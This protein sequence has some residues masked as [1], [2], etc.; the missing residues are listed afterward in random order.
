MS[1]LRVLGVSLLLVA[2]MSAGAWASGELN[3]YSI[4]PEKYA[5]Q[6]FEA[7]TAETGIK[8]NVKYAGTDAAAALLL[9]EGG[10]SPADV[11][12]SQDG[13]ALGAVRE[14]GLLATLPGSITAPGRAPSATPEAGWGAGPGFVAATYGEPFSPPS[15][16]CERPVERPR[17]GSFTP[18]PRGCLRGAFA[19]PGRLGNLGHANVG[20]PAFG[21]QALGRAQTERPIGGGVGPLVALG[22]VPV[23]NCHQINSWHEHENC[24]SFG[25][26]S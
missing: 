12:F 4:M 13:G 8:V 26:R 15:P 10:K 7:F 23:F 25:N 3:A 14:A 16:V 5:S 22:R 11:F 19:H 20:H 24:L 2:C 17:A 18:P 1:K 9:E 6:V 21:E